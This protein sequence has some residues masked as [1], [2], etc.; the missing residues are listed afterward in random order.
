MQTVNERRTIMLVDDNATNLASGKEMLKEL[1]KIYPVLSGEI[2]FDLLEVVHP[3]MILLDIEM[4]GMNGYQVIKQ[5]KEN[6]KWTDIPVIFLTAKSDEQS[7]YEGLSLGA[8]DYVS[9]P[10]SAPL[11]LKRI[12]NHLV[13][14]S[15]RK[16]L[17]NFND[18]LENLVRTKINQ[19]NQLQSTVL[20]T[21]S[22]LVE[23]RD[24]IT[25]GHI[26]RTQKYLKIL[27]DKMIE[28]AVYLDEV[29]KWDLDF[30]LPSAQLHDVGKIAISDTILNKEG[31][32][33]P[34]EFETMKSHVFEGIK[35]I[36]K[37]EENASE[38][39]FLRHVRLIVGS[40][41][42]KWDGSGYPNC[43]RGLDIPLEGRLMAIADVY[44]ALI[45]KRPYKKPFSTEEASRIIEEGSEKHFDPALVNVFVK[46]S[47]KFADVVKN[48]LY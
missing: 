38:H 29:K 35:A 11:L 26:V 2:L 45:S 5:L 34:E 22:G 44:D 33:T 23:F 16:M 17:Q 6:P 36:K 43:L 31:P 15:Q 27:I 19:V 47:D 3:D 42:E 7:E 21:I 30:L 10:F 8:V 37:I 12:E 32:L 20:S 25:G 24:D 14:Q 48:S 18:N 4:P 28:D 46:V 41:H 1:Y 39:S 9:K 40:H 13:S